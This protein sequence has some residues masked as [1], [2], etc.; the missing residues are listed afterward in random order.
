[1]EYSSAINRN[2]IE[3]VLAMWMNLE[4]VIQS[5]SEREKQ[6]SYINAFIQNLEK[7]YW[8]NYLQGRNR[9]T[10]VERTCGNSGGRRELD[11]LREKW[12][13]KKQ[14]TS[15]PNGCLLSQ[16]YCQQT[17]VLV[18]IFLTFRCWASFHML[19]GHF[20][21]LSI[22]STKTSYRKW[23]QLKLSPGMWEQSSLLL[24]KVLCPS[25]FKHSPKDVDEK[26]RKPF[27]FA[28]WW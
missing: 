23:G 8:W 19:V 22:H 24:D 16:N 10:N 25:G 28:L 11:E 9:D 21:R 18:C 14:K 13:K 5:E 27:T 6:I 15:H 4:P 3:S 12:E 7:W 17:V 26:L 20:L 2:K 1:M